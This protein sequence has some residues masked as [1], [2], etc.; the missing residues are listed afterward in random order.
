MSGAVPLLLL[1]AFMA[2]RRTTLR[3]LDLYNF[4]LIKLDVVNNAADCGDKLFTLLCSVVCTVQ[5]TFAAAGLVPAVN[6]IVI[7]RKY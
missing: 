1:C 4:S 2:W 7:P 3:L 5:P 6:S